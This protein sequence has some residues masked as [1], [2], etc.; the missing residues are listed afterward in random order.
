[1]A[2]PTPRFFRT[3]GNRAFELQAKYLLLCLF[4]LGARRRR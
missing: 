2:E 1:M 4:G 3:N